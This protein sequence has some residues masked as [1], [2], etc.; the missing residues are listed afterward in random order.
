M[1]VILKINYRDFPGG[2]VVKTLPSNVGG[3]G[4]IPGQGAKMPHAVAETPK[5]KNKKQ[6]CN[7]FNTGFKNDSHKKFFFLFKKGL[8]QKSIL[9]I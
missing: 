4:L 7:K 9:A 1:H 6:Y 5:H 3:A 2:P 8:T